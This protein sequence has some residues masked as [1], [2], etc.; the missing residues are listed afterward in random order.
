MKLPCI[1]ALLRDRRG[2]TCQMPG[3]RVAS[4]V[5]KHREQPVSP[6]LFSLC[7]RSRVRSNT[8]EICLYF[9]L[10]LEV[11]KRL[12][13]TA[14]FVRRP[15]LGCD[16]SSP[17]HLPFLSIIMSLRNSWT[18]VSRKLSR[19]FTTPEG[20][21]EIGN[22]L[23]AT[24]SS[25]RILS[26]RH[27]FDASCYDDDRTSWTRPSIP[28][29]R[30]SWHQKALHAITENGTPETRSSDIQEKPYHAFSKEQKWR[31]VV[32]IGVAGLFSGLSSNI[33]F[34]SLDAIARVRRVTFASCA[35][36]Y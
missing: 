5:M 30:E 25:I 23:Y 33:Y 29:S 7:N 8:F 9:S 34:P 4:L 3:P 14:C 28:I 2:V 32:M 10:T 27:Q 11:R 20:W 22:G 17:L 16:L 19:R 21:K 24:G 31:V 18:E 6:N 1:A 35:T 12:I 13:T 26:I 36:A 15:P